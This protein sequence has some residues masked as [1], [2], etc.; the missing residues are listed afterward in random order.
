MAE[1]QFEARQVADL[2][3]TV[4]NLQEGDRLTHQEIQLLAK[5]NKNSI[6]QMKTSL[7]IE[8]DA[9]YKHFTPEEQKA[10]GVYWQEKITEL[11]NIVNRYNGNLDKITVGATSD[12]ADLRAACVVLK[13][14]R[15][16]PVVA[17]PTSASAASAPAVLAPIEKSKEEY[18]AFD[19]IANT[20]K[21]A[22]HTTKQVANNA[23]KIQDALLE[24]IKKDEILQIVTILTNKNKTN[25]DF[26]EAL[27]MPE[28]RDGII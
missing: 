19:E 5:V 25:K 27:Q 4:N 24:S 16:A 14:L 12:L 6:V 7:E 3:N 10:H 21:I 11:E 1:N 23:N 13:S 9:K 17:V 8:R 18:P 2:A 22:G 26:Q 20:L 15:S 28:P